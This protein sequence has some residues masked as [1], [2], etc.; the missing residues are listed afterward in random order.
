MFKISNINSKYHCT[1][2]YFKKFIKQMYYF[3]N[4]EKMLF[5]KKTLALAWYP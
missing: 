1:F 3:N 5:L 2:P 4:E